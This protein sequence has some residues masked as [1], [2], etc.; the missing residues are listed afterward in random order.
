[1]YAHLGDRGDPNLGDQAEEG[2]PIENLKR[3]ISKLE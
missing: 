1:M 2:E 3:L